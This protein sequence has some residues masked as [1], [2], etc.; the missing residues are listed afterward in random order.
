MAGNLADVAEHLAIQVVTTAARREELLAAA[1]ALRHVPYYPARNFRE[2]VQVAM[3]LHKAS[4]LA[5]R[6]V[7]ATMS[8]TKYPEYSW[9]LMP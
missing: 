4:R 2:G 9:M 3:M 5:E 6:I 7:M 1:E 8:L